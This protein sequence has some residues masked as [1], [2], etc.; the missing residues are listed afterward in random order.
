MARITVEDCIDKI[1][2]RFELVMLAAQRA[3]DISAGAQL[4]IDRD[5]DK[6]PV[7][8]LREIAAETLDLDY[9]RYEL[10]HQLRR[11]APDDNTVPEG[12]APSIDQARD[13]K[14]E[15]LSDSEAAL[16][17]IYAD[18]NVEVDDNDDLNQLFSQDQ[19]P[20]EGL[21]DSVDGTTSDDPNTI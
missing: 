6:D 21:P 18:Q 2:N 5:K 17:G 9:L 7:V 20:K 1:P 11:Y 13:L 4:T 12:D 15:R 10:L 16:Q 19:H 8:A 3:R 14:P